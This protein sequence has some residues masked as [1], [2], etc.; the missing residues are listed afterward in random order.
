MRDSAEIP[1][2]GGCCAAGLAASAAA[3]RMT[4]EVA[5]PSLGQGA[6]R[7]ARPVEGGAACVDLMVPGIRCAACMSAIETGLGKLDG[8]G[9]ARVNLSLRRVR[10]LFDPVTGSVETVLARL[11]ELG[12]EARPY[13]AA[14]MVEI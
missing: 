10:V 9:S 8:V 14:A 2:P 12:Y 6:E 4:G 3:E 7:W 1:A 11:G 13:D 5:A